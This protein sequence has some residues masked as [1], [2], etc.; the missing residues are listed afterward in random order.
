MGSPPESYDARVEELR[1]TR[2]VPEMLTAIGNSDKNYRAGFI[3]HT[4][5]ERMRMI[6]NIIRPSGSFLGEALAIVC[7]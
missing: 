5:G 7:V 3:K 2:C 4:R 1:E 6:T